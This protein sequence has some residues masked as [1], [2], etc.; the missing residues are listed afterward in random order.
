VTADESRQKAIDQILAHFLPKLMEHCDCVQ[1]LVS[2]PSM[3][4]GTAHNFQGYGNWFARQGMA[5]EFVTMDQA[6]T[7][8]T[9]IARTSE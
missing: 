1:V 7:L 2:F 4:G 5:Q 3:T 6:Q 9:E 8:A